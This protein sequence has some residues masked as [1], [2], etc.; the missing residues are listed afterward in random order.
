MC[1]G[2]DLDDVLPRRSWTGARSRRSF[3]AATGAALLAL[4]AIAH[5][6]PSASDHSEPAHHQ[7]LKPLLKRLRKRTYSDDMVHAVIEALA[8]V[9]VGTYASPDDDESIVPVTGTPSP[10]KYLL[11]HART[12]AVELSCRNGLTGAELDSLLN[13]FQSGIR[14]SVL[15]GGYAKAVNSPGADIA[16]GLLGKRDWSHR[17]EIRL[18]ALVQALVAGELLRD[19]ASGS[20]QAHRQALTFLGSDRVA[21]GVNV[22]RQTGPLC[23]QISIFVTTML[24]GVARTLE[25]G[26]DPALHSPFFTDLWIG[27]VSIGEAARTGLTDLTQENIAEI[28]SV[29]TTV[30]VATQ[31]LGLVQPWSVHVRPDPTRTRFGV[32]A[33]LVSGS[34]F[35]DVISS[36]Q[37]DWPEDLRACAAEAG[38]DLP[39][40]EDAGA[41]SHWDVRESPID[42]ISGLAIFGPGEGDN[43]TATRI[44][45]YTTNQEPAEVATHQETDGEVD[46][47]VSI[48]RHDLDDLR[49]KLLDAL[50]PTLPEFITNTLV[51]VLA[52]GIATDLIPRLRTAAIATGSASIVVTY[53]DPESDA[54]PA[55]ESGCVAYGDWNLDDMV[56]AIQ[57]MFD[58]VESAVRVDYDFA[59]GGSILHIREDDTF[60]WT[61]NQYA[62]TGR[63]DDPNVG[64]VT[65]QIVFNGSFEG[66]IHAQDNQMLIESQNHTLTVS[67]EAYL[68]GSFISDMPVESEAWWSPGGAL[69]FKCG[70]DA[71]TMTLVPKLLDDPQGIVVRRVGA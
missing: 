60:R 1:D 16:R 50:L 59:G 18:P 7:D 62:I 24:A 14:P 25:F 9:G 61:F 54:T 46:V 58:S 52:V 15:V 26:T 36:G 55:P 27:M 70:P 51:P 45:M 40:V 69:S 30:V 57:A 68:N 66:V 34:I 37:E 65:V 19:L 6:S 31:V 17:D 35:A 33:E 64:T 20:A 28:I 71:D 42:L 5:A 13:E 21:T 32:G 4:P 49:A 23:Q 38:I 43:P 8:L 47:T 22:R 11:W 29:V 12:M 10:L 3:I 39:S 44:A 67:A 41:N 2:N 53:H 56:E 63:S 48:L